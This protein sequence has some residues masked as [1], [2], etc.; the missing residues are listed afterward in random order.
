MK[1]C[2]HPCCGE[3]CRK[4]KQAII[5][6]RIRPKS[7]KMRKAL[8]EYAKRRKVFIENNPVCEIQVDGCGYFTTDVHH[9][10]GRGAEL[11]NLDECIPACRN[12]HNW[13]HTNDAKARELGFLKSRLTK[14]T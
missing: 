10:R 8:A 9:P 5:R 7:D 12:C 2:N 3:T 11:M 4:A 13:V 1:A 14:T 6:Q